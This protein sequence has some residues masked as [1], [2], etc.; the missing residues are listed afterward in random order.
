MQHLYP[1]TEVAS[2]TK[3]TDTD[4]HCVSGQK[5]R[6]MDFRLGRQTSHIHLAIIRKDPGVLQ[7]PSAPRR[8]GFASSV[9]QPAQSSPSPTNTVKTPQPK[10][11]LPRSQLHIQKKHRPKNHRYCYNR[12][13]QPDKPNMIGCSTRSDLRDMVQSAPTSPDL[14]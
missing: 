8:E 12:C 9:H 7:T 6:C 2:G 3:K 1:R 5:F 11:L 10:T 14:H 4:V 13:R